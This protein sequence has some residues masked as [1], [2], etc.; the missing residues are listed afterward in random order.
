MSAL[1]PTLAESRRGVVLNNLRA[2]ARDALNEFEVV[3]DFH[4]AKHFENTTFRVVS[5]DGRGPL[6]LRISRQG[7]HPYAAVVAEMEIL[8][9]LHEALGPCVVPAPKQTPDGRLVVTVGGRWCVLLAEVPGRHLRPGHALTERPAERAGALL[10]KVHRAGSAIQ[11]HDRPVWGVHALLGDTPTTN[12]K[13]TSPEDHDW[14]DV[15]ER[16]YGRLFGPLTFRMQTSRVRERLTA[17]PEYSAQGFVHGDPNHTNFRFRRV[18][19]RLIDFDDCGTGHHAYDL[20]VALFWIMLEEGPRGPVRRAFLRGYGLPLG[21]ASHI[22]WACEIDAW[23]L[24]RIA[25]LMRYVS[26]RDDTTIRRWGDALAPRAARLH[27]VLTEQQWP[28]S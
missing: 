26:V 10:K 18:S 7:Y 14:L 6:F 20:A 25:V 15:V 27:K 4:L 19:A 22:E 13:F 2:V 28:P 5:S 23:V 12:S 24:A 9:G 21:P 11:V 17:L 16:R 1:T 3:G 8:R